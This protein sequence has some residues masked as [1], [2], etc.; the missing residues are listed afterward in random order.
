MHWPV[1]LHDGAVV[2]L[3]AIVALLAKSSPLVVVL[4]LCHELGEPVLVGLAE[5]ETS[6][7]ACLQ[8]PQLRKALGR[9][10]S[11]KE[12]TEDQRGTDEAP[13]TSLAR[14]R[15][16]MPLQRVAEA[17]P[18]CLP[19]GSRGRRRGWAAKVA[20]LMM[21]TREQLTAQATMFVAA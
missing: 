12:G 1:A 3:A 6:I 9:D 11:A 5:L 10:A 16:S 4:V 8:S 20:L 7:S 14:T 19:C 17:L 18:T 21:M 13:A 2:F 15:S